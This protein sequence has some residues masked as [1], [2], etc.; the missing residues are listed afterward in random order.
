M[1]YSK[2]LIEKIE[3]YNDYLQKQCPKRH[4]L[5]LN[6]DI[7]MR[8]LFCLLC[9]YV[10]FEKDVKERLEYMLDGIAS[11]YS[12]FLVSSGKYDALKEKY[13]VFT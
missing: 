11:S 4:D 13:R 1:V 10:N 7:C 2:E 6:Q 12:A 3:E 8:D 9:Q 5:L